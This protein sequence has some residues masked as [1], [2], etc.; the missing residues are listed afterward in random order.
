MA[1]SKNNFTVFVVDDEMMIRKMIEHRLKKREN[2]SVF[3]YAS[4]EECMEEFEEKNPDIVMLDYHMSTDDKQIMNGL[5]VLQKIKKIEPDTSVAM[6]SSQDNVGIAV[7]ALKEG[8]V[9][10]IVKN[11]LFAVNAE[12]TID[13]IIQNLTL[14]TEIQQLSETIKRDKL[15]LKGY[16]LIVLFLFLA[17]YY[18][19]VT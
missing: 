6:L 13:K 4:G 1:S 19:F 16:S 9:D 17:A 3:S 2:L 10:Y 11:T 5:E 15:M 8:A 14:S 18:F 12:S 7:N